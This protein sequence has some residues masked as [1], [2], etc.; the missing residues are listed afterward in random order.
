[1][2]AT[3][4]PLQFSTRAVPA[5]ARATA[6]RALHERGLLPIEPLP[7]ATPAVELVKWQLPGLSALSAR[8]TDVQQVGRPDAEA[9]DDL[10]FGIH[11]SG[12]GL[13]RQGGRETVIGG[14][15]AVAID[16]AAGP[17]AVVRPGSTRV[18]G[19]RLPRPSTGTGVPD[20]GGR[21]IDPASTPA[22][23]LLTSY[24][25]GLLREPAPTA[26]LADAVVDHITA[27]T[28]LALGA[29][30][31]TTQATRPAV[32]AARLAAITADIDRHLTDPALSPTTV[33]ERHG[34]S[35][36]HLHRLFELEGRTYSQHVL[37]RRLRLVHHR[38]RHPR[39]SGQS[40]TTVAG[41]AGFTDL[42]YFNRTFRR[43]Y[44]TTP[45]EVR[46]G[47]AT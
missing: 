39:Y 19:L 11:L 13:V 8:F 18:I 35:R 33:A 20:P 1:M 23:R 44:G 42:S 37:D 29:D 28:A 5:P 21:W 38:L 22:L 46:R 45:T 15:H 40:I 32:R 26:E 36:R 9:G 6:V 27:L 17:F 24:L 10:F 34:I 7:D 4:A 47:T 31:V 16:P 3:T 43:R 41:G 2:V 14:G 30:P 25:R 12:T